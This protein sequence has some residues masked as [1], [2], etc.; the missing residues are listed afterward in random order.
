MQTQAL[1]G[2]IGDLSPLLSSSSP[3]LLVRWGHV[4]PV[5]FTMGISHL[6]LGSPCTATGP[7]LVSLQAGQGDKLLSGQDSGLGL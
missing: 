7:P 3:P 4:P 5:P 6:Q 2:L 1:L